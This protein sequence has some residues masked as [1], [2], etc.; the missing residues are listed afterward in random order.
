VLVGGLFL[1]SGVL[2]ALSVGAWRE[3]RANPPPADQD[4]LPADY[5]V[6]YSH[7]HQDPPEVRIAAELEQRRQRLAHEQKE[8]ELLEQKLRDRLKQ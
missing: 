8:L 7:M 5:K 4:V 1:A 6:P 2:A 3:M